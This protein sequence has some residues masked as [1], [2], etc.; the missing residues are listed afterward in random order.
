MPPSTP[1]LTVRRRRLGTELR[2]LRER[3]DL[4]ATEAAARIGITQSRVSNI[5]AGRYG[6]SADRVRAFARSYD[7][8]DQVLIDALAAMTGERKRGWWEEYRGILPPAL[9]DLAEIEHHATSLRGAYVAHL[10]GLLQ[11]PEHA[12][13]IFRQAVPAFS[14]PEVEHRVSHRIKRQVVLHQ[15]RPTPYTAIIHE[16]ALRMGFGGASTTLGQLRHILEMS[17]HEHVTVLVIPFAAGD[18]P[19]SGQSV[20]YAHG[21]V[22]QLDA[23]HLDTEV[24]STLLDSEAK[25]ERYRVVLDRMEDVALREKLSR[26]LIHRIVQSLEGE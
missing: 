8:S 17:E 1:P 23:V 21:A 11:T 22:K 9:L 7:C 16:A 13:A 14:P 15:E 18:F 12:R 10:P 24:G 4:S 19:G 2:R 25:L 6:V 3:A 26:D 20:L 5:E